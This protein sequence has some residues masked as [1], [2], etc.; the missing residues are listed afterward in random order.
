MSDNLAS[1][2]AQITA[3]R[4][5][6]PSRDGGGEVGVRSLDPETYNLFGSKPNST[7]T[8]K[9]SRSQM[10]GGGKMDAVYT[11]VEALKAVIILLRATLSAVQSSEGV[12]SAG[13]IP[14]DS[15][16]ALVGEC[17]SVA[18]SNLGRNV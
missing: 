9:R 7:K 1:G 10:S 18:I 13:I 11:S 12:A 2:N 3:A 5:F 6:P 8:K 16:T 15:S 14:L 17:L 4:E